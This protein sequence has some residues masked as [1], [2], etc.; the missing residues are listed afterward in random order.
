MEF[1]MIF[2]HKVGNVRLEDMQEIVRVEVFGKVIQFLC[3]HF[4]PDAQMVWLN[5]EMKEKVYFRLNYLPP[6]RNSYNLIFLILNP[7][8]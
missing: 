1:L 3:Y 7:T 2:C 4:C 8:V 6:L 5:L